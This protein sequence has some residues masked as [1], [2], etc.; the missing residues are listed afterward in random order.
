MAEKFLS[1]SFPP[2]VSAKGLFSFVQ[3]FPRLRPLTIVVITGVAGKA[4]TFKDDLLSVC[5]RKNKRIDFLP[6]FYPK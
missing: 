4:S 6:Q 3:L 2:G 5:F 1:N